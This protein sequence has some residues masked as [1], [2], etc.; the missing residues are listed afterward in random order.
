VSFLLVVNELIY[1]ADYDEDDPRE[2]QRDS[3]GNICPPSPGVPQLSERPGHVLRYSNHG[4]ITRASGYQWGRDW[5]NPQSMG[6]SYLQ[7][8]DGTID[9]V[10]VSVG[11]V[12]SCGPH[13]PLTVAQA[14]PVLSAPFISPA[15][16]PESQF[17]GLV[18]P[19]IVQPQPLRPTSSDGSDS[20]ILP[21]YGWSYLHFQEHN[22]NGV[23]ILKA[24]GRSGHPYVARG[25]PSWIPSLVPRSYLNAG[26]QGSSAG[27][28]GDLTLLIGM[29]A[30][31]SPVGHPHQVFEGGHWRR[32][33][34]DLRNSPTCESRCLH[35]TGS[36]V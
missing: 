21:W 14:D 17:G 19:L 31:H 28:G 6:Y 11:S 30:F 4:R 24:G 35:A 8:P 1:V 34:W 32:G 3:W 12:F 16:L 23:S 7:A 13:L 29:M 25:R 15:P 10:P 18:Q 20:H 27:L 22:D 9:D 26:E 2:F 5:E 33:E 36:L